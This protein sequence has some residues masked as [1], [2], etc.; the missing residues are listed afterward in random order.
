MTAAAWVGH[1]VRAHHPFGRD[2]FQSGEPEQ[3]I[4]FVGGLPSLFGHGSL[5]RVEPVL[6]LEERLLHEET[7]DAL[8]DVIQQEVFDDDQFG[9][10]LIECLPIPGQVLIGKMLRLDPS[11]ELRLV[12]HGSPISRA[13][14][15][16]RASLEPARIKAQPPQPPTLARVGVRALRR[17]A[18]S[19]T[20]L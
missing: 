8:G 11:S 15:G 13:P 6:L 9:W 1:R 4:V 16:Y 3:T 7:A 19:S 5:D 14:G 20:S 2:P 18:G 10:M 17:R 12:N